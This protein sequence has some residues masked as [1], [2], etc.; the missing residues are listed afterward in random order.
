MTEASF[1]VLFAGPH[2]SIQDGGRAGMMR[3]G[4]PRSG[5]MDRAALAIANT[6]IG[7][8]ADAPAIEISMGGL[9]LRCDKGPIRLAVA[10]GGFIVEAAEK[11]GSWTQFT[12]NTGQTVVIRPGPWGSWAYLAFAGPLQSAKWLNSAA[13]HSSS[14]LGGGKLKTGQKLAITAPRSENMPPKPIPCP[15]WARP[16]HL[17]HV[18]MGPQDR[19]FTAQSVADFTGQLFHMS[20]AFDRMGM[21]LDGPK[22]ALEG[23]LSIPSAPISRGSVQVSGAGIT[24]LL[25]ADH[26]TTG[27]YPKIATVISADL[28]GLAQLRPREALRF[29]PIGPEQAIERARMHHARLSA[30]LKTLSRQRAET[31]A[32]KQ[33]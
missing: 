8:A 22:L 32:N 13:T 31:G 7:N 25:M 2:V 26:Q 27:G 23:A 16:R 21:R 17:A 29:Q 33:E 15:V 30:F 28:D 18:V 5:A 3:F 20:N 6:A 12:V 11:L 19:Y 9:T 4:V 24:T 14:G 1:T 10:G